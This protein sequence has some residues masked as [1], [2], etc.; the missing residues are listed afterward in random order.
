MC[1]QGGANSIQALCHC[2]DCKKISGGAY[3]VNAVVPGEGFSVTKGEPKKISKTADSGKTITSNFCGDCGS[4][5][6]RE[7]E[8][9]GT[10]KVVKLGV[11]DDPSE[12][13][14]GKPGVE[15]Y[16]P[17]RPSWVSPIS[18]ADQLKAMPGSESVA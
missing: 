6:F 16:A 10:S 17:E 14:N 1:A 3:S 15:L 18:G 9:F 13:E 8:T 5:L 7:G 11:M 12:V 4:T 2:A